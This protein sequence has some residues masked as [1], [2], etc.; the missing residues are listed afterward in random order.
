M[1]HSTPQNDS[2]V[3]SPLAVHPGPEESKSLPYVGGRPTAWGSPFLSEVLA[4]GTQKE[5][6]R[7]GQATRERGRFREGDFSPPQVSMSGLLK[8]FRE[9]EKWY[10]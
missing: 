8:S 3:C 10:I 2:W 5:G 1:R 9:G 6:G 7:T 4:R